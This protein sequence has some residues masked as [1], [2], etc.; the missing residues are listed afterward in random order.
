[1]EQNDN[2]RDFGQK[3]KSDCHNEELDSHNVTGSDR[4][5]RDAGV[6]IE[7]AVKRAQLAPVG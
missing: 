2:E 4:S 7:L 6:W 3:E 5:I 1:M